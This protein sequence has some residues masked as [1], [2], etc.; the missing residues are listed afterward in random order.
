[1][2]RLPLR[3]TVTFISFLLFLA[4]LGLW[5]RSYWRADEI[6]CLRTGRGYYLDTARGT[7]MYF[8]APIYVSPHDKPEWH[9]G[10]HLDSATRRQEM[11]DIEQRSAARL[12]NGFRLLDVRFRGGPLS[13]KDTT[14]VMLPL[15]APAILF[16]IAPAFWLGGRRRRF[17]PGTC[18]SCGYDLRASKDRCPECGTPIVPPMRGG[19]KRLRSEGMVRLVRS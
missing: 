17:A 13:G 2:Y 5:L 11:E 15:W 1:M 9:Y 4:T 14:L 6:Y 19:P 7:A 12:G 18:R 3:S 10:A 8:A 16:A